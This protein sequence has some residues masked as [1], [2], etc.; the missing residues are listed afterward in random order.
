M[1][2]A[3]SSPQTHVPSSADSSGG[4]TNYTV[5]FSVLTSLFF[6]W[7]FITNI[8]DILVPHLKSV[9]ELDYLKAA[10]VQFAF[11]TAY[12]VMAIPAG[13]VITRF[14]YKQSIVIG[15]C[16]SGVGALLFYPASLLLSY[17]VFLAG[18][19]T[20]ASGFTILQVAANPYVS[21]LGKPET[22]A[23]R[24][25]LAGGFNSLGASLGPFVGGAFI[26]ST[27]MLTK[28]KLATLAPA[29]QTVAKLAE[30]SSVQVPYLVLA[31]LLFVLA[32]AFTMFKL[33]T[34]AT[35]GDHASSEHPNNG[36]K[37]SVLDAL[38]FRQL[39]FGALGIFC[40]VGAEVTVASFLVSYAGLPEIAG[41]K[42]SDAA[43]YVS[44]Y[45][46]SA[47]VGRFLGAAL[48]Q[49]IKPQT[50][51]VAFAGIATLLVTTGWLGGGMIALLALVAVNFFNSIMWPNIFTLAID[52]LGKQTNNG[53]SLL[54][55]MILGGAL[56]PLAQGALAD[57][58]GLHG[59]YFL[60]ILCYG[61]II[62]YGLSGWKKAA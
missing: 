43:R 3:P 55:M 23:S 54:V 52:G 41:L 21:V 50:L 18:L 38:K 32:A 51:L 15:L 30:A 28:E 36:Q 11:F 24:L 25:N 26:L 35:I 7:G 42:E 12:F 17:W 61:Y 27:V 62:F 60:P 53:S 40:Y 4:S 46:G 44:F 2:S 59:S 8:N 16:T 19:F 13:K 56:V 49:R 14:G 47:M 22:A 58:I 57:V 10:F 45:W 34:I 1:A 20:L 5:A 9:F 6:M 29:D 33:P 31:G 48:T 37:G 39:R